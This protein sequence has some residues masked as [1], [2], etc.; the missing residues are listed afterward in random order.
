MFNS[1]DMLS[2][3]AKQSL[4]NAVNIASDLKRRNVDTEHILFGLLDDDV[5][6]KVLS[7][8]GV[9]ADL[10]KEN[11]TTVMTEGMNVSE[12]MEITP[13]AKQVLE[14]A[15]QE[16]RSLRHSYV[17]PEHILL[18]L[19]EEGEG[20]AAQI[21]KSIGINLDSAKK[22]VEKTV[23][24]GEANEKIKSTTPTLDK[25]SKDLTAFAREGKIDPVIGRAQE[26]TR[27]IQILSRRKKNNPVLIGDPGV[28]K[29]AIAE[30]LAQRIVTGDIP[31]ILVNK[32][33]MALDL[34]LMMSG[35]KFRGEFEE[36]A[37]KIISE[38]SKAA[39][40]IILFIDE[41]HTIVG[42]GNQEGGLD[43]SNILKPPLARGELQVIGATT[44]SEYKKYIE[45][46][47]ALERRF[48]PVLVNE[49]T[50]EQTIEILRGIRDKYETHHKI[51][52]S[53]EALIAAAE[54]SEKYINDRFLPDKAI[55]AVDE[56]ASRKRIQYISEPENI[57]H[58]KVEI[59]KLE[60]EREA[61][62]RAQKFEE[63]AVAKQ[64]IELKKTELE[65]L[66]KEWM[67]SRGTGT[68]TLSVEDIAEIISQ[69]T[70]IPVKQL[71]VEEK[72]KL[73]KLEDELHKR[74]IGQEEAVHAVSEAVRRARAGL[75]NPNRPI[76]SFIFLGPTGVGK[77]ELA[78]TLASTLFGS[79]NSLV[80]I[81]MSEYSEKFN[82]SRLI[83]SPPGYVGYDE[84]GQLTEAIRRNP[85]S[86]ILLDE[87]E[88]AH[89]EIFNVLLQILEDG[90]LTDGKGRVVDFKN[91]I[92]IATSNIGAQIIQEHKHDFH[93]G[94]ESV[95][96]IIVTRKKT[97]TW[98][99]VKM[100]VYNE[101]RKIFKPEFIN[102]IDE[103]IVFDS[104]TKS[105]MKDIVAL[106]LDKLKRL[107]HSQNIFINF[108][109]SVINF[110]FN[111]GYSDAYGAREIR[112]IIQKNLENELS[113][114]ILE[115]RIIPGKRYIVRIEYNNVIIDE[116]I[117][118]ES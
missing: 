20:M 2:E 62:T 89:P 95:E 104:L 19:I 78:K 72:E 39:G 48:Q 63:A 77:T 49:P 55:D 65:P 94:E 59:K 85:Y 58:L 67:Q 26:V 27:V 54:L 8:L 90:R 109:E 28:G 102:R 38:V 91:T 10:L 97:P 108:D 92:I 86:I 23:G 75:K 110:I 41:L 87:I 103:I 82:V 96:S 64:N 84:G 35:A 50:V 6:F 52:I 118:T 57:K 56:A 33:I 37:T 70:G 76:A 22:A 74:V 45:K 115:G 88:K 29:T 117:K 100:Q 18:G 93:N 105:Q 114:G 107:V 53:D 47:A 34:G 25:F 12:Q 112:R 73:I 101:M 7:E 32:R 83:G 46:D 24:E 60:Q 69:M 68:P 43:L 111:I 80:R 14:L 4:Q 31:D 15:F 40:N 13:R 61:L 106:E 3:R 51:T 30:G 17:G 36:R 21:L 98:D 42:T 16:S 5:V 113:S 116:V 1:L 11:L 81:D 99:E 9:S 66:N 79:E 71:K 44:L